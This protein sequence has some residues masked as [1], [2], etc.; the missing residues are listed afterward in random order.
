MPVDAKRGSRGI[1][2]PI[3][4]LG[5][6]RGGWGT[7]CPGRFAC[8]NDYIHFRGGCLRAVMDDCGE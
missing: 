4:N 5:A 6:R 2:P 8:G 7:P 3:L 1:V